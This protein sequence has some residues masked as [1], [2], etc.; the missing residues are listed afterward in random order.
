MT[1][2]N[3]IERR[4]EAQKESVT[5]TVAAAGAVAIGSAAMTLFV[6]VPL[7]LG[8]SHLERKFYDR[9]DGER[10]DAFREQMRQIAA[11][12]VEANAIQID[13]DERMRTNVEAYETGA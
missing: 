3:R 9:M 10:A 13:I 8:V 7:L 5:R 1:T 2:F 6:A 12:A 4:K 11:E